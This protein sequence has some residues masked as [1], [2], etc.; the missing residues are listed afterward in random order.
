MRLL[1]VSV[2]RL[3]GTIGDLA[4]RGG[5]T[6]EAIYCSLR[7][8]Q[9]DPGVASVLAQACTIIVVVV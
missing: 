3:L 9:G 4:G 8:P 7:V 6:A 2:E 5:A 1:G